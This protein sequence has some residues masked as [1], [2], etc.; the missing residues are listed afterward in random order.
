MMLMFLSPSFPCQNRFEAV[1]NLQANDRRGNRYPKRVLIDS[2]NIP[3]SR[4]V[5]YFDTLNASRAL[6]ALTP[7]NYPFHAFLVERVYSN[8]FHCLPPPDACIDV[9]RDPPPP[10]F[11]RILQYSVHEI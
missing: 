8:I 6:R 1:Q 5:A 7:Q 9:N 4:F 10:P 11:G 2:P 3:F